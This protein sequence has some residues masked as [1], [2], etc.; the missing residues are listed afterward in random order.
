MSDR[1]KIIGDSSTDMSEELSKRVK[2]T[3]V[4]LQIDLDGVTYVDN[5]DLK[6]DDMLDN[7]LA[8]KSVAKTAAP[9][10]QSYLDAMQGATEGVFIITLSSMLSGSHNSAVMAKELAKEQYPDLKVEVIDSRAAS[11]AQTLLAFKLTEFIEQGLSFE[12]ISEKIVQF[13][14]NYHLYFLLDN[15]D[16][17]VKNGRL[18]LLKGALA[19]FLHIKPIL[20]A[21]SSG[22]I[23]MLD[24]KR[25]YPKALNRLAELFIE[26]SDQ[27]ERTLI[28]AECRAYDRAVKLK[29]ILEENANFKEIIIVKMQGLSSTYANVGGLV[30]SC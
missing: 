26:V 18:S 28:I 25:T 11:A 17:L 6:L 8:S 9:S 21:N 23:I 16:T 7:I 27:A 20:G 2:V 24:K 14:D 10:P 30:C 22:E 19:S 3:S 13:R 1:I 4:A 15:L 29:S 5:A 12:E